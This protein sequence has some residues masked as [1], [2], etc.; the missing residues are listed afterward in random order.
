MGLYYGIHS[1]S[2]MNRD[3]K[4]DNII[5]NAMVS[6]MVIIVIDDSIYTIECLRYHDNCN[7]ILPMIYLF[8]ADFVSI[9][10]F[11]FYSMMRMFSLTFLYIYRC[12]YIISY[13]TY[14]FI[15]VFYGERGYHVQGLLF[16]NR[17][18]FLCY[19]ECTYTCSVGMCCVFF[20]CSYAL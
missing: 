19:V 4:V 14:S 15:I 7:I 8:L 13:L 20:C 6:S 16:F 3:F 12:V 18:I 1:T 5:W 10:I 9:F 11:Y 17:F 2:S